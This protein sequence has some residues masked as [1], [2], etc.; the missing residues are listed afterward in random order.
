M[1]RCLL[2]HHS[3]LVSFLLTELGNHYPSGTILCTFCILNNIKTRDVEL[4]AINDPK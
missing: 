4:L 2:F 3:D 1:F